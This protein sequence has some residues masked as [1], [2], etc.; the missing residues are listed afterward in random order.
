MA[1]LE[2]QSAGKGG[3]DIVTSECKQCG[4]CCEVIGVKWD[5]LDMFRAEGLDAD[6]IKKHWTPVNYVIASIIKPRWWGRDH[7][8][9]NYF[10]CDC[11]DYETR[12]C[13]AQDD[14]PPVCRDYPLYTKHENTKGYYNTGCGYYR[15]EKIEEWEIG[16][17]GIHARVEWSDGDE[18]NEM[19]EK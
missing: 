3:G 14:K 1:G 6:F 16:Q 8:E 18:H 15:E 2:N 9:R 4:Q 5:L 17:T 19:A 10:I 13:S 7:S 11:F 12:D